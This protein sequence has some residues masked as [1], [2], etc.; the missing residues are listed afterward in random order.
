MSSFGS[1]AFQVFADRGR[2]PMPERDRD[3]IP[4][5]RARIRCSL[6]GYQALQDAVSLVTVKRALGGFQGT[7]VVEA[8]PPAQMLTVPAAR[9]TTQ[10]FLALLVALSAETSGQETSRVDADAEWLLVGDITP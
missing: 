9:G 1:I 8:G 5:Y 6:A 10:A 4:R 7:A 2:W 3:G